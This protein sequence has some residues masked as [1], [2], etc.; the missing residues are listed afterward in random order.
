MTQTFKTGR[1]TAFAQTLT[2]ASLTAMLALAATE[3]LRAGDRCLT[4]DRFELWELEDDTAISSISSWRC[5]G[6]VVRKYHETLTWDGSHESQDLNGG[7]DVFAADTDLIAHILAKASTGTPHIDVGDGTDTDRFVDDATLG[8]G[9]AVIGTL[10]N[11]LAG[12]NHALNVEVS[13][14]GGWDA[15]A[16]ENFTGDVSICVVWLPLSL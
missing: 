10:A 11:Q 1:D 16:S 3:D 13:A 12:S 7:E 14:D 5:I 15:D 6:G 9:W 4:T 8:T 2:A